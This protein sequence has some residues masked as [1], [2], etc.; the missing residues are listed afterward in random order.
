[1][2]NREAKAPVQSV[3]PHKHLNI[4][5][6]PEDAAL[7]VTFYCTGS[8][9]CLRSLHLLSGVLY[10][11]PFPSIPPLPYYGTLHTFR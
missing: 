2:T 1:M 5:R 4:R 9:I 7:W 8:R 10:F 11:Y 6:R 3:S